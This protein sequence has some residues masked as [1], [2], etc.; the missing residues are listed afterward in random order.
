MSEESE[1]PFLKALPDLDLLSDAIWDELESSASHPELPWGLAVFATVYSQ[2]RSQAVTPE[3]RTLVL[4]DADRNSRSLTWHTD[5][6]SPKVEQL[7]S[8]AESSILFWSP[9][10]RVQLVLRCTTQ[11]IK[12]GKLWEEAWES[13]QLTS[14]RAYLGDQAPGD[15][16][17]EMCV[18]F[19]DEFITRPPTSAESLA[20]KENFAVLQTIA[21]EMDFLLLRQSGNVRVRLTWDTTEMRWNSAWVCP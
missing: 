19:P 7:Q 12:E 20:G 18:N 17:G 15:E 16:T 8:N 10:N 11:V 5:S 6:R 1:N 13:S 14:R 4:R 3:I 21:Y 9:E 2:A